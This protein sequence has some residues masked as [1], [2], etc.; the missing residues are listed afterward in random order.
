M[1]A[2]TG[3]C[4]KWN[5]KL[6]PSEACRSLNEEGRE[7]WVEESSLDG[8]CCAGTRFWQRFSRL[9][10][11]HSPI[12]FTE[13]H[14]MYDS[15]GLLRNQGVNTKQ[16][17]S[18]MARGQLGSSWWSKVDVAWGSLDRLVV[19]HVPSDSTRCLCLRGVR[20]SN[21]RQDPCSL[22]RVC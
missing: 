14:Q 21:W 1:L 5:K 9:S 17:A 15:S 7:E 6:F 22:F 2:Y 8:L 11:P 4:L 12:N 3:T 16:F 10:L 18:G 13:L 20:P 19:A